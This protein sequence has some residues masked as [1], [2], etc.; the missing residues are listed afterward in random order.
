MRHDLF[1]ALFDCDYG[2]PYPN[3]P[4]ASLL[5]SAPT[6]PEFRGVYQLVTDHAVYDPQ[7]A[8]AY[9]SENTPTVTLLRHPLQQLLSTFAFF[10][11]EKKFG[12]E[13]KST[14]EAVRIYLQNPNR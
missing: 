4:D 13:T 8:L 1:F 11:L 3:P 10:K 6:H 7:A 2:M 14:E 5:Y 9:M 12:I